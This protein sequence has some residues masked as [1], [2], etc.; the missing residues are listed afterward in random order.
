MQS[1]EDGRRL[2]EAKAGDATGVV[3][4]RVRDAQIETCKPGAL[5]VVQNAQVHVFLGFIRVEVDKWGK[6][7]ASDAD[8]LFSAKE[9]NDISSVQ[10]E[11]K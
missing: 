7:R 4:L 8:H 5:I 10:Y 11:L 6:L 1:E 9:S 3:T 2:A